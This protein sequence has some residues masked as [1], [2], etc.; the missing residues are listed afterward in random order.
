MLRS[1]SN[2]NAQLSPSGTPRHNSVYTFT[3]NSNYWRS[4]PGSV[5]CKSGMWVPSNRPTC[6]P[7]PCNTSPCIN[8]GTCHN[9]N[10]Y[11][12]RCTCTREWHGNVCDRRTVH[13]DT[14]TT[15]VRAFVTRSGG[16]CKPSELYTH[17]ADNNN[18]RYPSYLWVVYCQFATGSRYW[19]YY[20]AQIIRVEYD[21]FD[22]WIGWQD[23]YSPPGI[24]SRLSR[25]ESR[26]ESHFSNAVLAC[27]APEMRNKVVQELG[28]L[29]LDYMWVMALRSSSYSYVGASR[30]VFSFERDVDCPRSGE[31]IAATVLSSFNLFGL[32]DNLIN[33]RYSSTQ[34]ETMNI[35][36]IGAR[37]R[38]G[39]AKRTSPARS[40]PFSYIVG[41]GDHNHYVITGYKNQRKER[42][43]KKRH[44]KKDSL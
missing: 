19:N 32:I 33:N 17:L 8:G 5:V 22:V 43:S 9:V 41:G 18:G 1:P 40:L 42:K 25:G 7:K 13:K 31:D 15:E 6:R 27:N 39:A 26:A 29:N 37:E 10:N 20:G 35:I 21:D 44:Y 23:W 28:S 24:G 16:A 2:G 11:N 12:Y 3:C 38:P 14:L 4:G 30:M 34:R 36:V